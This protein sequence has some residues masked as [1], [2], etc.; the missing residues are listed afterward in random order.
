MIIT[1]SKNRNE[2][3]QYTKIQYQGRKASRAGSEQRRKQILEAALRIIVREGLRGVRHRSVAK[4][5]S[6][7]LAAT[8]YYF[9]D[10]GE[11]ITDTFTHYVELALKRVTDLQSDIGSNEDRLAGRTLSGVVDRETQAVAI[12]QKITDFIVNELE[13]GRELL[14]AEQAFKHE[15][16]LNPHLRP[17]ALQHHQTLLMRMKEFLLS[18]GVKE[19]ETEANLVLNTI[20]RL[21]YEGLLEAQDEI[22]KD[23]IFNTLKCLFDLIL[24]KGSKQ[25]TQ[26][27]AA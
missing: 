16:L 2:T 26:T 8:T 7:P 24:A 20:I 9:K 19:P 22:N 25:E 13:T 11:L 5:A 18:L 17:M 15:A 1:D 3:E 6:V 21:E 10:I 4:E 23:K 27:S 14:V 12:V